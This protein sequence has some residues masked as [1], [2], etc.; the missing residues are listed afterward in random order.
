MEKLRKEHELI[1]SVS[2][3]VKDTESV[4]RIM[5]T[6]NASLLPA[7]LGAVYYFGLRALTVTAVA[8]VTAMLSEW[9]VNRMT[10]KPVTIGDG[11]AFLTGLLLGLNLPVSSPV[12]IPVVGSFVAVAISK[13]LFGGLG[14][15]IFNPA[16]VGRAF[17]LITWP[18]AMTTWHAPTTG[19][20]SAVD[21]T[22]TATPLGVLKEEGLPVLLEQFG[23][24]AE[25]YQSLFAGNVAG[26]LGETS[27]LLLLVGAA[28]LF[29]KRYITWHTPFSYIATV[30]VLA[31]IFGGSD[32]E[33]GKLV[34]FSGDP[35]IHV[36][37]GGLIMGAFYMATDY[38]TCPSIRSGQI[39]FGIGCGAI[40]MLIRLKGGFPEGVMFAILLMNCFTPLIDRSMRSVTFGRVKKEQ[41]A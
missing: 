8:I 33:T 22:T 24:K 10:S 19:F 11:S 32:A 39:V 30:A 23:S 17:V 18:R 34:F 36:L 15:N 2:P 1:V 26:S 31:W 29:I 6:V 5:W 41:A 28:V 4:S 7:L 37:S 25:L 13:M 12:Y 27:V 35:L 20:A 3:H 14:F 9:L 40:T 38:V 16:L 21:A